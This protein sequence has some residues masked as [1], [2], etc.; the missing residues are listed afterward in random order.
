M[1]SKFDI[2]KLQDL[3]IESVADKLNLTVSRHK[4]LCPFHDD[5]RPSLTFNTRKNR[6]RCFVCNASGGTIDLVMNSQ[7]WN[8]YE[9]CQ[10]LAKEFGVTLSTDLGYFQ[11][12]ALKQ[13]FCSVK[14]DVSR[15]PM[16]IDIH[17]LEQLI[18]EPYLNEEAQRFLYEERKISPHVIRQLGITSIS[19]PAPMTG[20]PN[21]TWF[22][23]P[24]LLIPYRDINGKL[25][26]VQARY[27]GNPKGV[28]HNR[29][30]REG[31]QQEPTTQQERC[32]CDTIPRFQFPKGSHCSIFNLPIIATLKE[33][34]ELWITEGVTDCLAVMSSGRKAIA[35]PSATLLK[36]EDVEQLTRPLRESWRGSFHIAPDNDE[37]G[38]KLFLQLQKLLPN[39]VHHLL[40]SQYKDFGEY[41]KSVKS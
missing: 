7:N 4:A 39:I 5:S 25:L 2:Q 40:P 8:F 3:S 37:P 12:K 10:W 36:P 27:L 30:V 1:L 19:Q 33:A 15:P 21:G 24:S 34:E 9:S 20:N 23:A 41:W 32:R 31:Y 38:T 26:S 17:H 13:H 35:I 16:P 22:N 11:Q 14:K 28:T 29:V 18:A 6:Y